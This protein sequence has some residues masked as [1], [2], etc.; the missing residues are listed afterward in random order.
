MVEHSPMLYRSNPFLGRHRSCRKLDQIWHNPK[1]MAKGIHWP[2]KR[3]PLRM[4]TVQRKQPST[5]SG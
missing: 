2:M 3:T 4:K 1:V 5:D